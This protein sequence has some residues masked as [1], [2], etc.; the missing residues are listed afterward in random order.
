MKLLVIAAF[1]IEEGDDA[2]AR[3]IGRG[4]A[5]KGS[6]A[7]CTYR[8]GTV[9]LPGFRPILHKLNHGEAAEFEPGDE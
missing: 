6:G 2:A 8:P 1:W 4:L 5:I 7:V 9:N 3:E